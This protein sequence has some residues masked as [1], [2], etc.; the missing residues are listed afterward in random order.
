MSRK[1]FFFCASL[2]S[3]GTE[4]V[5]SVLSKPLADHYDT[6]VY[7]MWYDAPLYY[8]IDTRIKILSLEKIAKSK[9]FAKK[10]AALRTFVK[11]EFP[12]LFLAFGA[13]FSMLSIISLMG[14]KCPVIA[15]ERIDPEKFVRGKCLR[16]FR[17]ILYRYAD[18]ILTQT[19]SGSQYFK[20]MSYFDN[21]TVIHNPILMPQ[22]T[23]G[24]ALNAIKKDIVISVARLAPQKN[25]VF[26]I[27]SFAKFHELHPTYKL[28]IYGEGKERIKLEKLIKELNASEYIKLPG[29]SKN[30]WEYMKQAKLF[31][32]TSHYEGMSNSML[33][34]MSLGL[35]CVSTKVSGAVDIINHNINGILIDNNNE[36]SLIN[37]M[38]R[39]VDDS[40]FAY[41]LGLMATKVYNNLDAKKIAK[42]W[43][44]YLDKKIIE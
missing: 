21:V 8:N 15:L 6:V 39:I 3:G 25:Q 28:Y 14:T 5:L 7:L 22:E 4:R 13:P 30:V 38:S 1:L 23:I 27:N 35:P 34:A 36:Q 44:N 41:N 17:D 16:K 33:E 42:T 10:I 12:N 32:L 40:Q 31:V 2:Q 26:L 43:I 9:S 29:V 20:N 11:Q 19:D 24:S 18:G 37:E